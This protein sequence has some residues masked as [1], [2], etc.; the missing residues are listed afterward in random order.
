MKTIIYVATS[1]DGFIAKKD[2]DIK[3]LVEDPSYTYYSKFIKKVGVI[4]MGK[5]SY[6]KVLSFGIDWPYPDAI[7]YVF[8][9]DKTCEDTDIIKFTDEDIVSFMKNLKLDKDKYVWLMGGADLFAQFME[10]NLVDELI[11]GMQPILLGDGI[12]LFSK[13]TEKKLELKKIDSYDKG[14]IQVHYKILK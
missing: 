8:T 5:N 3:W 13:G 2:G 4:L 7:S 9:H 12:P 10:H 1:L 14:S 6:E 11:I